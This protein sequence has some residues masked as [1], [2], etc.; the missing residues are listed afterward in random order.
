MLSPFMAPIERVLRK[1]PGVVRLNL[2]TS[3]FGAKLVSMNRTHE[4]NTSKPQQQPKSHKQSIMQIH[5]FKM[6]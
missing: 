4:P 5:V 2:L 1:L 3:F 6:N